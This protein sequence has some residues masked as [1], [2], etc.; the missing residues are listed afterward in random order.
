MAEGCSGALSPVL[1]DGD[2]PYS[3]QTY[4]VAVTVFVD[5]QDPFPLVGAEISRA[6]AVLWG[7]HNNLMTA[8]TSQSYPFPRDLPWAGGDGR[9]LVGKTSGLPVSDPFP[10]VGEDPAIL[11]DRGGGRCSIFV[12]WTKRAV[13]STASFRLG[14][15]EVPRTLCPFPG[16]DAVLFQEIM[17]PQLRY[18]KTSL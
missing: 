2:I 3:L 14:L 15:D 4:V 12:P 5:T 10:A 16:D 13:P 6:D 7:L 1:E 11:V 8:Q 18:D 17:A 9:I